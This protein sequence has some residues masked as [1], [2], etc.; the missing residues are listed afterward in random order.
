VNHKLLLAAPY[1]SSPWFDRVDAK[2][3]DTKKAIGQLS[4]TSAGGL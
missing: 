4:F 2:H 1:L 3:R